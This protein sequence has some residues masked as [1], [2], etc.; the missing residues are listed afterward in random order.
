[1][2]V[3]GGG[4]GSHFAITGGRYC[5]QAGS[6]AITLSAAKRKVAEIN[7]VRLTWSGATSTDIDV[8]RNG[9]QIVTTPN[10]GSYVDSTGDTGR[11]R[12]TY[13][14]CEAG[15]QTCSDEATVTF[16]R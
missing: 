11:A 14:V 4:D 7:T 15:T 9:T 10:D 6:P 2:I 5:A 1:M 12:Y 16:Q 8:Y 13:Q 3:W